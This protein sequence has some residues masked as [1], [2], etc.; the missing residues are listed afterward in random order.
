MRFVK[1]LFPLFLISCMATSPV[2]QSSVLRAGDWRFELDIKGQIL[3]FNAELAQ[4]GNQYQMI[5]HNDEES[6]VVDDFEF[7]GD[8]IFISMPVFDSEFQGRIT[9][10]ST[11]EGLWYN[12]AKGPDYTIPFIARGGVHSRFDD[13]NE[14]VSGDFSG[15]WEVTFS[16][17][18][19]D[20][21]KAIGVFE[22]SN[23]RVTGTF[24]TET[25]DLRFFEG[26]VRG[27]QMWMSTF[28]GSHAF[29]IR[30]DKD[31]NGQ[32]VGHFWSG[33][34]WDEAWTGRNN[35]NFT[36]THPD[37]L[38]YL[39]D[40]YDHLEF[41]FPNLEGQKVSLNDD[42][43]HD[44][45]VIV[46]IMGSWCPNC[47]DETRLYSDLFD[48]YHDQGLE[49]IALAY[50]KSADFEV[51]SSK[52][53]KMKHDLHADYDFLIAG[54]ASKKEAAKTLPMLNHVMSYPTSIFIDKQGHIRKIHTG[55]YG[56]GTGDLYLE[57]KSEVTSFVQ[58]LLQE[59][60]QLVIN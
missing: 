7:R 20:S 35:P 13:Q 23:D 1:N 36:L 44:K 37:S 50:E 4:D 25:G 6:I 26:I 3:P 18:S 22:Q 38:T 29:L 5:I 47:M 57:Y 19:E 30:A 55:F 9:S 28:D 53:S 12:F 21:C 17:D 43:F 48:Q 59:K 8:S 46:Q 11:I 52:V 34:H 16:P 58:N 15:N 40:G 49:I 60:Q 33:T 39:N 56:P 31:E 51:A 32:I 24:I 41:E 54:T 45:V 2:E 42:R 10:D 14:N 27:N